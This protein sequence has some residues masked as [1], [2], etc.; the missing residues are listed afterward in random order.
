MR[1]VEG[2]PR[3]TLTH[4]QEGQLR[5]LARSYAGKWDD[6]PHY[7]H[8]IIFDIPAAFSFTS[9]GV[10]EWLSPGSRN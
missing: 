5:T 9:L 1:L 4:W 3:K 7:P 6:C 2:R 10:L 8:E